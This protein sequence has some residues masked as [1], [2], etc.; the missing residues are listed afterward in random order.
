[1]LQEFSLTHASPHKSRAVANNTSSKG[2]SMPA[3]PPIQMTT[4]DE[5]FAAGKKVVIAGEEHGRVPE[6]EEREY[7]G[8]KDKELVYEDGFLNV[9][10]EDDEVNIP[11]DHHYARILTSL[12]ILTEGLRA[13]A[14]SENLKE[15]ADQFLNGSM[16]TIYINGILIDAAKM[17]E[18]KYGGVEAPYTTNQ[19]ASARLINGFLEGFFELMDGII[20]EG[21]KNGRDIDEFN[22]PL[23]NHLNWGKNDLGVRPD[24]P[25]R[26]IRSK[27]MTDILER[28]AR[29]VETPSVYKV[30]EFHIDDIKATN[31]LA[32][33][34]WVAVD[35]E[36]YLHD[37]GLEETPD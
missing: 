34:K 32:G 26:K 4:V 33:N 21:T 28:Y 11:P 9:G 25:L 19:R 16:V 18:V 31:V 1:M 36:Q 20:E 7:W 12:G 15:D 23:L 30:G 2:I 8:D 24:N 27:R 3:V 10:E 35:K 14:E 29:D 37:T 5:W 13:L 22:K 17:E 6:T